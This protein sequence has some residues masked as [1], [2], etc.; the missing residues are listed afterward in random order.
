MARN[1]NNCNK[2]TRGFRLTGRWDPAP[3]RHF[4]GQLL[5]NLWSPKVFQDRGV[6]LVAIHSFWHGC[7]YIT[8]QVR[9]NHTAHRMVTWNWQV[10]IWRE[11]RGGEV[12]GCGWGLVFYCQCMSVFISL[13]G[14]IFTFAGSSLVQKHRWGRN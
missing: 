9:K 4:G 1:S 8:N 13:A 10:Y 14:E 5:N 7:S 2:W 12:Q 6:F 3:R 11:I